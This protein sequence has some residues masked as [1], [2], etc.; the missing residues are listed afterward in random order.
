[1]GLALSLY[2]PCIRLSSVGIFHKCALIFVVDINV[3]PEAGCMCIYF[4]AA[5]ADIFEFHDLLVQSVV[6]IKLH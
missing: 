4:E 6:N 5:G 3:S 1:M 2:F